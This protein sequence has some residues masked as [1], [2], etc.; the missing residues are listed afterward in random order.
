MMSGALNGLPLA[1]ADA[2]F[3]AVLKTD[4]ATWTDPRHR[5]GLAAEEL[6]AELLDRCGYEVLAHRW[7]VHRHEIDLI[8][9]RGAIVVFVEVRRRASLRYGSP[10]ESVTA[11]KRQDLARAAGAWLQRHGRPGDAARFDVIGVVGDRVEW[12]QSAFRPGW[13]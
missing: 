6:A 1:A 8:A 3:G 13:R 11:R 10:M 2:H 5:D 4:P 9:R 12:Q 7:R